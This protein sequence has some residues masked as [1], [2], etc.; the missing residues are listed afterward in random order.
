MK[1]AIFFYSTSWQNKWAKLNESFISSFVYRHH[2][3]FLIYADFTSS[4]NIIIQMLIWNFITYYI[5]YIRIRTIASNFIF[6]SILQI[7]N[8][9]WTLNTH[10]NN[11]RVVN[12]YNTS[13]VWSSRMDRRMKNKSSTVEWERC[14]PWVYD[15]SLHINFKQRWSSNFRI[16]Q[17]KWIQ[18]KML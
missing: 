10:S 1:I 5:W 6:F 2:V 15:I 8:A 14:G 18:K 9:H 16:L 7:Y 4:T 17:T 13:D 3:A 12:M 11:W